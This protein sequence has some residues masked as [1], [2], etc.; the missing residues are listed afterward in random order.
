VA[1]I[2]NFNYATNTD[3]QGHRYVFI[4]VADSFIRFYWHVCNNERR[5][6]TVR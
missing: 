2:T 6:I 5:Q 4:G 1:L 3:H